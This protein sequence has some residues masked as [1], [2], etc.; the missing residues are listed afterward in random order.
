M[1]NYNVKYLKEKITM[2]YE[3]NAQLNIMASSEQ[4]YSCDAW[5]VCRTST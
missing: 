4:Q 3:L 2:T 1:L 5:F